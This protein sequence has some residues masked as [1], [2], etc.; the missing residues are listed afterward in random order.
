MFCGTRALRPAEVTR[1][2][3][4]SPSPIGSIGQRAAAR[5]GLLRNDQHV[6]EQLDAVLRQQQP[7]QIPADGDLAVLDMAARHG[8]GVAE[9]DLRAGRAGRAKRQPAE[10][11]PGRGGLGALANQIEREFTI[12]GL[13]IVVEDLQP[14][15][16]GAN[17][18]D[19]IMTDPRTQQCR[20]FEGVGSDAGRT[21]DGVPDI[22]FS[23][24]AAQSNRC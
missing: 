2:L 19:E 16:D 17:R 4:V 9:I 11:Q 6:Q 22:R 8:L 21:G 10:L 13:R 20:K 3:I 5:N 12:F 24:K 23:W 15:D 1:K 18:T 7:R 14:I